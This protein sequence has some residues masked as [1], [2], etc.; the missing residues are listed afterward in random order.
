MISGGW[1]LRTY[2]TAGQGGMMGGT[3]QPGGSTSTPGGGA[4]LCRNV[5]LINNSKDRGISQISLTAD[6]LLAADLIPSRQLGVQG[7]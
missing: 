4:P 7:C 3:T 1:E 5:S 2:V 6:T